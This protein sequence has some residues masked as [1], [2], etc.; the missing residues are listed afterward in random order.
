M[1]NSFQETWSLLQQVW[2][3]LYR[4][5]PEQWSAIG[6]WAGSIGTLAAV[7]VSLKTS[8]DARK[9]SEP[10]IKV[11]TK[12]HYRIHPNEIEPQEYKFKAINAGYVPVVISEF[13]IEV[14]QMAV[15]LKSWKK[16][17]KRKIYRV[18]RKK[19]I[20]KPYGIS[21]GLPKLIAPSE[22]IECTI[23]YSQLTTV[24]ND[25][26]R[27]DG[28]LLVATFTDN[29]GRIYQESFYIKRYNEQPTDN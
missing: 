14:P 21:L 22:E 2:N 7:I 5:S 29:L 3:F 13:Y 9:N 6:S 20:W 12:F 25:E 24:F 18:T 17:T 28:A 19:G 16:I 26:G 4:L 27:K 11:L 1:L 10:K 8:S 23:P 15:M